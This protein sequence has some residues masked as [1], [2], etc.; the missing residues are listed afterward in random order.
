[1]E[2]VSPDMY[3]FSWLTASWNASK[4]VI[5]S[6]ANSWRKLS[7]LLKTKINGRRLLY[8][9]LHAYSMLDMKVDGLAHRGVSTT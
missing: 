9:M 7:V 2:R 5:H 8:R 1:M 3:E 4:F 6:I